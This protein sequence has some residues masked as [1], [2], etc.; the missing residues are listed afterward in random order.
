MGRMSYITV[1]ALFCIGCAGAPPAHLGVKNGNFTPCPEKPNCVI[2]KGGDE[3][4]HVDPLK[5][6]GQKETAFKKLKAVVQSMERT[7]IIKETN[8][9]MRVEFKTALMGFVD[10]VEFYFPDEPVIHL[11]SASRMGYWDMGLNRKR[12]EKIRE[13]FNTD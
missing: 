8:D 7:R 6:T 4:H 13:K 2:S 1:S 12:V 3:D 9:Y 11:K 5:Y 10:D